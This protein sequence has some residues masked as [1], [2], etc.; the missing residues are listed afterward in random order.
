MDTL[1][2]YTLKSFGV[3]AKENMEIDK[4]FWCGKRVVVTGH[5]GFKASFEHLAESLGA[6]LW[7]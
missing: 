6:S 4:S 3:L 7:F 1:R 5:T 2:K